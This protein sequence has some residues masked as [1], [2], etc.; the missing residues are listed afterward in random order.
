MNNVWLVDK[1]MIVQMMTI[2][3]HANPLESLAWRRMKGTLFDG[4]NSRVGYGTASCVPAFH[5]NMPLS[6]NGRRTDL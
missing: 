4:M 2:T 1:G 3:E 5:L 6:A